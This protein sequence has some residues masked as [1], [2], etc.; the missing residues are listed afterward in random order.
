IHPTSLNISTFSYLN[1]KKYGTKHIF[2][3]WQSHAISKD[4]KFYEIEKAVL[5]FSNY[6]KMNKKIIVK[7][8]TSSTHNQEKANY[9]WDFR[10]VKNTSDKIKNWLTFDLKLDWMELYYWKDIKLFEI[11]TNQGV[12]KLGWKK[13]PHT[14]FNKDEI[15]LFRIDTSEAKSLLS[16]HIDTVEVIEN[17]Q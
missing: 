7:T 6:S 11:K 15:L 1:F 16:E 13:M 2:N 17:E 10:K 9:K 4:F 5:N 14:D 3:L 8:N 12:L